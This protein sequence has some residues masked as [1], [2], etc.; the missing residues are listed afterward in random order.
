[1]RP[2]RW[3]RIMAAG[4]FL[5]APL[6]AAVLV[7]G[8]ARPA[9]ADLAAVG[10]VDPGPVGTGFP[11]WFED[12][13]GLRLQLC[14]EFDPALPAAEQPPCI[15]ELIDPN[16]GFV[17][18]NIGEALFYA[19]VAEFD[20]NGVSVLAQCVL[21]A[22]GPAAVGETNT[23][24]N[25]ALLRV[26]NLV[27]AGDYTV[28]T[29]CATF[30]FNVPAD[31]TAGEFRGEGGASGVP[32]DFAGALPGAVQIFA[33]NGTGAPGFLGDAITPGPLSSPL[34]PLGP[35]AVT[36]TFPDATQV[37]ETQF[38]VVG[39]VSGCTAD[40]VAPTAVDDAAA[41]LAATPVV[42]GVL[43][44]DSDVVVDP[45]EGPIVVTP[46]PG[47]VA[48]V[49]DSIAPA[50]SGAAVANADGT[51]TFTPAAGFSGVATFAY[52]V[53]DFCGLVSNAAAVTVLVED[54]QVN[55]AELRTKVLKWLVAGVTLGSPEGT[56]MTVHAGAT[57]GGPALGTVPVGP[58]GTWTLEGGNLAVPSGTAAVSVESS[59]GV[60]LL[61][62]PLTVR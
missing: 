27:A 23:V 28:E 39:K 25:V 38:S 40:N 33:S 10:P 4:A 48:I 30:T 45:V 8:T 34:R 15:P 49:A 62:Q 24:G 22:A 17:D 51:V 37:S 36:I 18:G 43:A 1:M 3:S 21:E 41:T 61:N 46:A 29:P 60:S 54:I 50:G 59:N 20:A 2:T 16:G 11:L 56:T 9:N 44:N 52:T 32:P 6:A 19:A 13:V 5:A 14:D 31:I 35:T 55:T 53:T 58:D 12:A 7:F 26:Q 47:R 57:L 42:V